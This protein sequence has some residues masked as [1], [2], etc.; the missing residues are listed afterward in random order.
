MITHVVIG[1]GFGDEGKGNISSFIASRSYNLSTLKTLKGSGG[2]NAG[3][4][5]ILPNGNRHVFSSFSAPSMFTKQCGVGAFC[6]FYP[7]NLLREL[8]VLKD[9]NININK[10]SISL[11]SFMVTPYD[12]VFSRYREK[13]MKH[14]STGNGIYGAY[15]RYNFFG[16]NRSLFGP[17]RSDLLTNLENA[18][19]YYKERYS[20]VIWK[21]CQEDLNLRLEDFNNSI[22]EFCSIARY[23]DANDFYDISNLVIECSQ[24]I[25]LDEDWGVFPYVTPSKASGVR[26]IVSLPVKT[27]IYLN[28]V[29]RCYQTRHGNGPM[30]NNHYPEDLIVNPY[31]TNV[32]N[33]WQGNFRIA[34][35]DYDAVNYAITC[36]RLDYVRRKI[37]IKGERLLVTCMDQRKNFVIDSS[38]LIIPKGSIYGIDSDDW[39]KITL[40]YS[41]RIK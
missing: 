12:I 35:F 24:G 4:T 17:T 2:H 8:S 15:R 18:K 29:V 30:T 37:P 33:E 28:Y 9:N 26:S 25:L 39:R 10:F 1:L 6:Y 13:K 21:E 19:S 32:T 38:K 5:A 27:D 40:D 20:S 31:E 22:K 7:P 36:A 11:S 41:N 23:L 34:E 16:Y 3:H 14:G